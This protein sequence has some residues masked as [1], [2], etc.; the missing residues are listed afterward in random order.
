MRDTVDLSWKQL[1]PPPALLSP[2]QEAS[3]LPT[4]GTGAPG[5]GEAG[6]GVGESHSQSTKPGEKEIAALC[7]SPGL[8]PVLEVGWRPAA[9][10]AA[11]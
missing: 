9:E 6:A 10:G 1:A 5:R 11:C 2:V 4:V 8:L 7:T 3:V